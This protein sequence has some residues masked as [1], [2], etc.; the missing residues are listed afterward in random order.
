MLTTHTGSI[1]IGFRLG[2]SEWQ[3]DLAE[4]IRFAKEHDFELFD[5]PSLPLGQLRQLASSGLRI[6]CVDLLNDRTGGVQWSD[7]GSPDARKRR[8]AVEANTQYI[9]SLLPLGVSHF[10]VVALPE[11][12]ARSRRENFDLAVDGFTELAKAIEPNGARIVIEGWPGVAPYYSSLV[13]TPAECR[14]FFAAVRSKAIG[15]NFDPSHL[16]RMGIDP[17][18]FVSEFSNRILHVHA[19]DTLLLPEG[20]YECGTL[21]QSAVGKP[22]LYGGLHWRYTIA[23][24]GAVPWP[25]L[26][27]Q[28][29]TSDYRGSVSIELE[30]EQYT[31]TEARER[32]GLIEA[33]KYLK[34]A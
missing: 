12:H 24:R 18:R 32:E 30:D 13:C 2:A 21:Q 7:L 33:L 5:V 16:V 27:A 28:L 4:V 17:L 11:D 6:D 8:A 3:K 9:R 25:A 19:K 29:Q 23:G 20:Q 34:S 26:L 31:G 1:P 15:I 14:A 10:L 22:H